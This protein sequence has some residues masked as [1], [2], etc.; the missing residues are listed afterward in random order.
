M[1]EQ[2]EILQINLVLLFRI[3]WKKSQTKYL[4]NQKQKFIQ[5]W[6]IEKVKRQ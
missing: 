5:K 6:I 1:G 2:M 4:Y 3:M